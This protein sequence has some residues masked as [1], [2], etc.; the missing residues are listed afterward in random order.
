MATHLYD[1]TY[2]YR[3]ILPRIV[4]PV[5]QTLEI[6]IKAVGGTRET[7]AYPTSPRAEPGEAAERPQRPT[8]VAVRSILDALVGEDVRD[9]VEFANQEFRN[10]NL[11]SA[12]QLIRRA[13]RILNRSPQEAGQAPAY[14]ELPEEETTP[15][16]VYDMTYTSP[17]GYRAS[18]G[19]RQQIL[20]PVPIADYS[21]SARL[22]L[23]RSTAEWAGTAPPVG[24]T[25][26]SL[27]A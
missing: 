1:L 14:F 20:A 25:R 8:R 19:V 12:A 6:P 3:H 24:P 7:N 4:A 13:H 16:G 21:E 23:F 10:G 17:E 15:A 2:D 9:L 22:N 27:Y 18:L 26:V 5:S 11:S